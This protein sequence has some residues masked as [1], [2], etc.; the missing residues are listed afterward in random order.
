[1]K[2]VMKEIIPYII[3]IL[4]VILIKTYIVSPIRVN[5]SSMYRTLHDKDI[6]ILNKTAYYNHSI[7]RFD[8]VVVKVE[9]S[10]FIPRKEH[11]IKRV[12]GLPGD[13]IEYRNNCLYINGKKTKESFPHAETADFNIKDLGSITVPE[14]H[15]FVL[16]DNRI[17]S[18]DSRLLGFIKKENII[19]K[20]KY[21]IL[22]IS[23]FGVKK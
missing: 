9:K 5:G 14:N 7:K 8:I 12:I 4:V 21:T 6:M 16:G 20:A 23:R 15:Y 2:S 18:V 10:K 19:G 13:K 11:I 1:M 17:N 22:P 3:I